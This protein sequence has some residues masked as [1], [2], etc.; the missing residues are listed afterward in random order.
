[1]HFVEEPLHTKHPSL[2]EM[3]ASLGAWELLFDFRRMVFS[4]CPALFPFMPIAEP[5]TEN[6]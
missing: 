3:N 5:I 1:M 2:P 4:L 6:W